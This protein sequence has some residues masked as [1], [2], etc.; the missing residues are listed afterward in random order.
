MCILYLLIWADVILQYNGYIIYLYNIIMAI[1]SKLLIIQLLDGSIIIISIS[2]YIICYCY[3]D[4]ISKLLIILILV[5]LL[6]LYLNFISYDYLIYYRFYVLELLNCK[7]LRLLNFKCMTLKHYQLY[8]CNFL[9]YYI[10]LKCNIRFILVCLSRLCF[11]QF[12]D[13]RRY[14][15]LLLECTHY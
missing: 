3:R 8:V 4:I 10:N 12:R 9:M 5:G 15:I 6:L 2:Y 11:R 1:I 7:K 13:Q 14:V